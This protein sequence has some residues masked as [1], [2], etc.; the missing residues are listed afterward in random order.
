ML[1]QKGCTELVERGR[2]V[3]TTGG[4]TKQLGAILTKPLSRFSTVSLHRPFKRDVRPLMKQ[5]NIVRY[6][7]TLPLN[8]V[9]VVGTAFFLG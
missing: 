6:V 9:P 1:L 5:D 4:R 3:T 2:Q 7:L 8:F